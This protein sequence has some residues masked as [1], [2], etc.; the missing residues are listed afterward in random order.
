MLR[1]AFDDTFTRI[2]A[3]GGRSSEELLA[4]RLRGDGYA[5]RLAEVSGL[6]AD[7]KVV[8]LPGTVPEL[9]GIAG[10]RGN[11]LPVYDLGALMGYAPT[12]VG[13]WLIM[14]GAP[15]LVCLAVPAF[16]GYVRVARDEV[17]ATEGT[18]ASRPHVR[19][20]L[21]IGTTIRF[22]INLAS[23]VETIRRRVRVAASSQG[24]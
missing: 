6:Q 2:P 20:I 1:R 19:E 4:V 14:V 12:P 7:R 18:D 10:F 3:P 5:V 13:R 11:I 22:V 17:R 9:L 24:A 15:A 21:R 8:P 23:V 16:E